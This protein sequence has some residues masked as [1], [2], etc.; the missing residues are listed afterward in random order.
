MPFLRLRDS[1]LTVIRRLRVSGMQSVSNLDISE[2]CSIQAEGTPRRTRLGPLARGVIASVLLAIGFVLRG[3]T[4]RCVAQSSAAAPA[5]PTA[6]A[7]GPYTGTLDRPITFT[8]AK[9]T[10]PAGQTLTYAWNFGDGA[11]GTGVTAAHAYA[12][13]GKYTVSLTVADKAG[14]T[15]SATSTATVDAAP[16][17]APGG[18]YGGTV[19]VVVAFSGAKSKGPAGQTLKY[20]WAF[21]DGGIGTGATATHIYKMAGSYTVTL[22]VTDAI[23]G[24]KTASTTAVIAGETVANAGGTY[25]G[26][27]GAAIKFTGA[28]ST[29]PAGKAL[30][31]AWKFGDGAS[32]TG[33]APSHSYSKAGFY[34]VSL[35]VKD[36]IG[37]SST[38]TT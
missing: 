10:A 18:T 4:D 35:T 27:P 22:T 17:A 19:G 32:A 2:S 20:A 3:G 24:I 36:P 6:N 9:S 13:A 37:G 12:A 26:R 31:Y 23:G 29:G 8:G 30:T 11:T 16:V 33:E 5:A 38:A 7:G 28:K 34:T 15:V 14:A 1:L 25:N 21:G